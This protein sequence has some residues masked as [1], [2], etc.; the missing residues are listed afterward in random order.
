MPFCVLL[1]PRLRAAP[2]A[3]R[4]PGGRC[5]AAAWR[6]WG[7]RC[8]WR[9]SYGLREAIRGGS[10]GRDAPDPAAPARASAQTSR[11][12]AAQRRMEVEPAIVAPSVRR[13]AVRSS[14]CL[15]RPIAAH[16]FVQLILGY[17][18][19]WSDGRA[20]R[21]RRSSFPLVQRLPPASGSMPRSPPRLHDIR[22]L[23]RAYACP[24]VLRLLPRC[25]P[26][27]VHSALWSRRAQC[28]GFESHRNA[29]NGARLKYM[30]PVP[31]AGVSKACR[32]RTP[33]AAVQTIRK[34][35]SRHRERWRPVDQN[36]SY[37]SG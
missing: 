6:G 20:L 12:S 9:Y 2:S 22:L 13:A 24:Q 36:S 17:C 16:T 25:T 29:R 15:E 19:W 18:H 4:A 7:A 26:A 1:R 23:L 32:L 35:T 5:A 30:S 3:N 21:F 11:H 33:P 10:P 14:G 28:G 31:R 27:P 8:R 34:H 37:G